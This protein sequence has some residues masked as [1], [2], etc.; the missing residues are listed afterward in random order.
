MPST[1]SQKSIDVCRSAPTIV[2]WCTP[3]LWSFR[4]ATSSAVLDELR[5][6]LAALQ[7]PPRHELDLASGRR[8]RSRSR[9]G[10]PRRARRPPLRPRASSTATG[11]G[12]SCL[13]PAAA[14]PDEDVAADR[15]RERARRPR[16]SPTGTRSRRARSACRRCGRCSARAG[17]SGRRRRGPS[18]TSTW[19]RVRKRRSGAARCRRCVEHE[20]ARGAVLDRARRAGLGVDQLGVDEAAGAEVHPVL[21]LALAPERDPDVADSHRLGDARAPARLELGAEGGLAAA[22]LAGDQDP[23]D[24]RR[25]EVDAAVGRRTRPGARRRT[26]SAPRPRGRSSSIAAA[27]ARCCP[28]PTGMWQ[29]PMRSNG[30][31]RRAGHERAGVVGRDDPL[32]CRDARGGVAARRARDPVGEVA[33]GQRDVARRAGRAARRVDADDLVAA[34]RRGGRR[35]GARR[36]RRPQL[37][38]SRSAAARRSRRARRPSPA[39][40]TPPRRA[41][42]GRTASARTGSASCAR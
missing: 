31:E 6:V 11:S 30:V 15:R 22:G 35:S 40:R 2:M 8:A 41:W 27:A 25:R 12:G 19:S 1:P 13:T 33:G 26:A 17:R 16:G 7:A 10:S 3:W 24:A 14:R 20:L 34:P 42:R 36:G 4:I 32:A 39:A 29:R 28:V 18:R 37:A 21:L 5:L 9:R 38:A 23:L